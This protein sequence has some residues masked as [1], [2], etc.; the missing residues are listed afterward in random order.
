MRNIMLAILLIISAGSLNACDLTSSNPLSTHELVL[1][2]H[3]D[4]EI[5]GVQVSLRDRYGNEIQPTRQVDSQSMYHLQ[6]GRY[7]AHVYVPEQEREYFV[8]DWHG[9]SS[10]CKPDGTY[11][12]TYADVNYLDQ[13]DSCNVSVS[14]VSIED[15]PPVPPRCSTE[16]LRVDPYFVT[17]GESFVVSWDSQDFESASISGEGFYGPGGREKLSVSNGKRSITPDMAGGYTYVLTALHE[18][19]QECTSSVYVQVATKPSDDPVC[20][21]AVIVFEERL[22]AKADPDR[23]HYRTDWKD[24]SR[25]ELKDVYHLS[26]LTGDTRGSPAQMQE[27]EMVMFELELFSGAVLTTRPTQDVP[28]IDGKRDLVVSDLGLYDFSNDPVAR[29]RAILPP[30]AIANPTQSVDVYD[31]WFD[32]KIPPSIPPLVGSGSY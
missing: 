26:A 24:V 7:R 28:N 23:S 4:S 22:I 10:F 19:G 32:C 18:S 1:N 11:E 6:P 31:L 15:E 3:V 17:L 21:S 8:S 9:G 16:L 14:I 25:L 27:Y 2:A 20:Y 30:V 12:F 13:R 5:D 29:V